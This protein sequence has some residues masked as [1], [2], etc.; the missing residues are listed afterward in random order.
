MNSDLWMFVTV[1][2]SCMEKVLFVEHFAKR[3]KYT[4]PKFNISYMYDNYIRKIFSLH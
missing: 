3:I 4:F 1:F 2:C